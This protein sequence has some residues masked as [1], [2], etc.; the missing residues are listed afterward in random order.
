MNFGLFGKPLG[1]FA[2]RCSGFGHGRLSEVALVHGPG[3]ARK[4]RKARVASNRADLMCG[5]TG[6]GQAASS[7]LAQ[8]VSGAVRQA[9]L[10]ALFAEPAAKG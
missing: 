1:R 10:I 3:V 6:L 5:A 7:G 8:T 9:H 4:F 2:N